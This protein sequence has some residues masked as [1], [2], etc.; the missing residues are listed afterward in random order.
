[1]TKALLLGFFLGILAGT[2]VEAQETPPPIDLKAEYDA[3]VA[4]ERAFAKK[5]VDTNHRDAFLAYIA[6]DGVIFSPDPQPGKET[7]QKRPVPQSVLNWWPTYADI[8]RSGD[9]G[10]TTGP[11]EMKGPGKAEKAYGYFSTVW[12]RQDDGTWRFVADMGAPMPTAP[13]KGGDPGPLDPEKLKP[14]APVDGK[15]AEAS[16][17]ETERL[18]GEAAGEKGMEEAYLSILSDD[19]RLMRPGH[20]PFVGKDAAAVRLAEEK[21][22]ISFQPMKGGVSAAGD[23][24]YAYGTYQRKGEKAESGAYLRVWE[25]EPESGWRLALE[26]LSPRMGG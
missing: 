8:S 21:G 11:W 17:L 12:R 4:N 22:K 26:V 9:L 5:A 14:F 23:L 10:W 7:L 16:L 20:A 15:E 2:G 18:L 24:G 1:M 25:R 3:L 19:T 6:E 13:P